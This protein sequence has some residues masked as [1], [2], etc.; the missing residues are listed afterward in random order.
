ME[1]EQITDSAVTLYKTRR[2]FFIIATRLHGQVYF[3]H[4]AN[5][6]TLNNVAQRI[7]YRDNLS[8]IKY[9]AKAISV[10]N[11]SKPF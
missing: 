10:I 5:S 3:F 9:I 8:A 4:S 7:V 1:G 6:L 11:K 2:D